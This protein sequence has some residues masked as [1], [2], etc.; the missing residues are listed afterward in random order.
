MSNKRSPFWNNLRHEAFITS[1]MGYV[2][3]Y[4]H[5]LQFRRYAKP[6]DNSLAYNNLGTS[7]SVPSKRPIGLGLAP[8]TE[9]LHLPQPTICRSTGYHWLLYGSYHNGL[10][11]QISGL[12]SKPFGTI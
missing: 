6:Q 4:F 2:T 3:L 9:I 5:L 10:A 12:A 11:S 8:E 1:N 7:I